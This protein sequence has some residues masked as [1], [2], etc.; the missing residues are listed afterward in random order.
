M[1][2]ADGPALDPAPGPR[3]HPRRR[4][5]RRR[6]RRASRCRP[7]LTGHLVLSTLHTNDAGRGAHPLARHGRRAVPRRVVADL[8]R[9]AA[10]GAPGRAT[11]ARGRTSPDPL[12][13]ESLGLPRRADSRTPPRRKGDGLRASAA[14]PATAAGCGVFE[15]LEVTPRCARCCWRPHRGGARRRSRGRGHADLRSSALQHAARGETT[16]TEVDA[17]PCRTASAETRSARATWSIARLRA[18]R[19]SGSTATPPRARRPRAGAAASRCAA[20]S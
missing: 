7:S 18:A 6:D 1:T 14:A 12:L 13:A 15:V 5:P 8:R 11:A 10:A 3:R 20:A 9:R 2:F 4:G 16:F 19:S 17:G